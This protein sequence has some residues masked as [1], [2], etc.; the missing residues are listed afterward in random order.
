MLKRWKEKPWRTPKRPLCVLP[1]GDGRRST[2]GMRRMNAKTENRTAWIQISGPSEGIVWTFAFAAILAFFGWM[3][4]SIVGL[5]EGQ[6]RLEERVMRI[7][8]DVGEIKDDVDEIKD[9][10]DDIRSILQERQ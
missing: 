1:E 10:V 8:S 3:A 2:H 6:V 7:E 9:N 4:L 5:R